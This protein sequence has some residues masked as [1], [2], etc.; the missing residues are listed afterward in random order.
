MK[1]KKIIHIIVIIS[2]ILNNIPLC[3]SK[4]E[5]ENSVISDLENLQVQPDDDPETKADKIFKMCLLLDSFAIKNLYFNNLKDES[6]E[7]LSMLFLGYLMVLQYAPTHPRAKLFYDAHPHPGDIGLPDRGNSTAM[8][9]VSGLYDDDEDDVPDDLSMKAFWLGRSLQKSEM[10]AE[11]QEK[12]D[13]HKKATFISFSAKQFS[14]LL[15]CV[16][17][18]LGAG[19]TAGQVLQQSFGQEYWLYIGLA[20]GG[21]GGWLAWLGG[22]QLYDGYA[23]VKGKWQHCRNKNDLEEI[24]NQDPDTAIIVKM[25]EGR[26]GETYPN[27]LQMQSMNGTATESFSDLDK[28]VDYDSLSQRKKEKLK[29]TYLRHLYA[30]PKT[31]ADQQYVKHYLELTK[32]DR[33]NLKNR[34]KTNRSPQN[35]KK[36]K[37]G[38]LKRMSNWVRSF[39]TEDV[40]EDQDHIDENLK[41]HAKKAN[42]ARKDDSDEDQQEE[43][44]D[45]VK[46]NHSGDDIDDFM[47]KPDQ[48]NQEKAKKIF[49]I[50]L[51][52]DEFAIKKL[53]FHGHT[54]EADDLLF[55]LSIGYQMVT[56]YDP[57][58]PHAQLF[59]EAR[60]HIGP[61]HLEADGD[62][63]AQLAVSALYA[64]GV[65]DDVPDDID[66]QSY[67]VA[68]AAEEKNIPATA[69]KQEDEIKKMT[70]LTFTSKEFAALVA[71]EISGLVAG[72]GVGQILVEAFEK[73]YLLSVGLAAGAIGGF[74]AWFGTLKLYDIYQYCKIKKHK[75]DALIHLDDAFT[76]VD[77]DQAHIL[78]IDGEKI[79]SDKS[80]ASTSSEVA[81][82]PRKDDEIDLKERIS[83]AVN[84][85]EHTSPVGI[86]P[87]LEIKDK[88]DLVEVNAAPIVDNKIPPLELSLDLTQ[89]IKTSA[90]TRKYK[91]YSKEKIRNLDEKYVKRLYK[92]GPNDPFVKRY[93]ELT[94]EDRIQVAR[95][96]ID[97]RTPNNTPNDTPREDGL[98]KRVS[99]QLYGILP[100]WP[101][102]HSKMEQPTHYQNFSSSSSW[103]AH[104]KPKRL[105]EEQLLEISIRHAINLLRVSKFSIQEPNGKQESINE[106]DKKELMIIIHEFLHYLGLNKPNWGDGW[107]ENDYFEFLKHN[108]SSIHETIG[109]AKY[110]LQVLGFVVEEQYEDL[111]TFHNEI[112]EE[113]E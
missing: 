27:A 69:K 43:M 77:D 18:G 56:T 51:K 5:D 29:E 86:S 72:Y 108:Q 45:V 53:H 20:G 99:R 93:L 9:A 100:H 97:R 14:S 70:W 13:T 95:Q 50:L 28:I 75:R 79:D 88:S 62:P 91:T 105:D 55:M 1:I 10:H 25:E 61:D 30:N 37:P 81:M 113:D 60:R 19:F 31:K 66:I 103:Q 90:K 23:W 68:K 73:D 82:T 110:I 98:L 12:I 48:D 71:A 44:I 65:D 112:D 92:Y 39:W 8:V 42:K 17:T 83:D 6:E 11:A 84:D 22:L 38:R 89:S 87:E 41:I 24:L 74:A 26:A 104:A 109:R 40:Q 78:S 2:F 21:F 106:N 57:T 52:L 59:F 80:T 35:Q 76:E 32:N 16:G 94:K 47:I 46:L 49:D 58:H 54:K 36:E 3:F 15:A 111:P 4:K 64:D 34:E 101:G 96:E 85:H 7:L 102:G 107:E 33:I 63:I 67:W